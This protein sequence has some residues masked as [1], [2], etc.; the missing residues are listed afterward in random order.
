M[1]ELQARGT[2]S[3][4]LSTGRRLR[5]ELRG[6]ATATVRPPRR[7]TDPPTSRCRPP[8]TA[9][10]PRSTQPRQ[11]RRHH[12]PAATARRPRR[13]H[14]QRTAR[15]PLRCPP[16]RTARRSAPATPTTTTT[17]RPRSPVEVTAPA[18]SS[19]R[20]PSPRHP[21]GPAHPPPATAAPSRGT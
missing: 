20:R 12:R 14:L 5:P 19:C 2:S 21:A 18:A 10:H 6:P 9:L 1:S 17:G 16:R 8:R 13:C 7:S 3:P 11:R 15:H 4:S